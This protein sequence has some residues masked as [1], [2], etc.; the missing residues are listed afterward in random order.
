MRQLFS[1]IDTPPVFKQIFIVSE[2]FKLSLYQIVVSQ[3]EHF[4]KWLLVILFQKLKL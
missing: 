1:S 2:H 3:R 4:I